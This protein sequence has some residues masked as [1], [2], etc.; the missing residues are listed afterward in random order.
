MISKCLGSVD[1]LLSKYFCCHLATVTG[2]PRWSF[3]VFEFTSPLCRHQETNIP[4]WEGFIYLPL[5]VTCPCWRQH[6][7][8]KLKEWIFLEGMTGFHWNGWQQKTQSNCSTYGSP[9]AC[10]HKRSNQSV[11]LLPPV[12]TP[13]LRGVFSHNN[14]S[15]ALFQ[16]CDLYIGWE[17]RLLNS[18]TYCSGKQN[19]AALYTEKI[20]AP[21]FGGS[22]GHH[23]AC[24]EVPRLAGHYRMACLFPIP[25]AESQALSTSPEKTEGG[26]IW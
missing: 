11:Q 12:P 23:L 7:P 5:P 4:H 25:T 26:W 8:V 21:G 22:L 3:L 18:S 6:M 14:H 1:G 17:F 20:K 10:G 15:G 19:T 24:S 13:E 2:F 9:Q 16:M